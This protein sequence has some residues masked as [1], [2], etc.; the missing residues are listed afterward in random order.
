M[1]V[2]SILNYFITHLSL[3]LEDAMR[4]RDEYHTNYGLSIKG[5]VQNHQIDPL[6]FNAAVD[7]AL[8]LE[9]VIKPDAELRSLLEDIDRERVDLWLLTN[10]YITH[11][12]RVVKLLQV[13][14]LFDGLTFCDYSTPPFVCKPSDAM[15]KKA[16][17]EA[18][19]DSSSRCFFVGMLP[20]SGP[21]LGDDF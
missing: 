15:Y 20:P 9:G 19:V 6:E 11:A 4:L 13:D 5:L 2:Q 7:D 21:Y 17:L 14:D 1:M 3:S 8:P 18:G 12:Q 10:A 16:M